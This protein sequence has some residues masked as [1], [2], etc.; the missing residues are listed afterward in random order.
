M[1]AWVAAACN[2]R[3][4]YLALAASIAASCYRIASKIIYLSA[5]VF[6]GD[7]CMATKA[8]RAAAEKVTVLL[9]LAFGIGIDVGP[10]VR[11]VVLIIRNVAHV[12]E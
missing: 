10:V 6:D 12:A 9:H 1:L 2:H 11:P 7:L 5:G 3:T 4:F 8:G